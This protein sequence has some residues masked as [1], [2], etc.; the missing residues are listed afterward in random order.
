MADSARATA[1]FRMDAS[2]IF[3]GRTMKARWRPR[4]PVRGPGQASP[5]EAAGNLPARQIDDNRQPLAGRPTN[6]RALDVQRQAVDG[7]DAHRV[8]L[9]DGVARPRLPDLALK[10]DPALRGAL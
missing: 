6:G 2:S 1:S 7:R 3:R 5:P 10:P 9:G 8:A 4:V